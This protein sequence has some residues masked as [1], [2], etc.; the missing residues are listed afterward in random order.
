MSPHHHPPPSPCRLAAGECLTRG[1]R[2]LEDV[3]PEAA[4]RLYYDA[5]D[6]YEASEKDAYG[7]DAF[8]YAIAFLIKQVR[9][10]TS[11]HACAIAH[12][13]GSGPVN[14]MQGRGSKR[15]IGACGCEQRQVCAAQEGGS[16]PDPTMHRG[17]DIREQYWC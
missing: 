13:G 7:V 16:G 14:D 2:T 5:L 15:V 10:C 11:L 1:A 6:V 12:A 17:V 8:R 3:D 9:S 4:V